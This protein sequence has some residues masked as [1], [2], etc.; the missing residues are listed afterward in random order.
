[1]P[2][3][4]DQLLVD[5]IHRWNNSTAPRRS[6]AA[7]S[8]W[9]DPLIEQIIPDGAS[10]LD[11]GC[12]TG[13]LLARLVARKRIRAQG[14]ELDPDM[15]FQSIERGVE[16]FMTD[17]DTGLQGF[18]DHSFDYVILEETLQ[19]LR[20]PIDVLEEML[21]VGRVGIISFPNFGYWR[22]RAELLLTGQMPRTPA[23]PYQWFNTPNIHL[24][25]LQDFLQWAH[26]R[27]VQIN[28][29]HSL[30]NGQVR[31]LQTGD[32]LDAEEVLLVV[33]RS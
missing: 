7:G 8:R 27:N 11:L 19:T 33:Q 32:D 3:N 23:L 26:S 5:L 25:T 16:V 17:L 29:G 28:Q 22:V 21:R 6:E 14:I 30:V 31:P 2:Q 4:F 15:V 18:P 10:V 12:G 24:C 20:R 13:Q 9:Q 1:M